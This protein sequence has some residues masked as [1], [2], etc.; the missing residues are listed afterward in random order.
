MMTHCANVIAVALALPLLPSIGGGSYPAL[1]LY[2]RTSSEIIRCTDEYTKTLKTKETLAVHLVDI[3]SIYI[4]QSVSE[5]IQ[6][7]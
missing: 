7:Q 3:C 1:H 5:I 6:L 2:R 4:R